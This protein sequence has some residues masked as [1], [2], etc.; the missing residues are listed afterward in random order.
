M[1]KTT[2]GSDLTQLS[3]ADLAIWSA[4]IIIIGDLFGLFA[5]I[6]AKSE[7]NDLI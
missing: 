1:P 5:V 7:E 3:A 6:K 2:K 4:V